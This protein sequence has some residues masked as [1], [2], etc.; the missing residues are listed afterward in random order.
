M[1]RIRT[2]FAVLAMTALMVA[3][4]VAPSVAQTQSG[5]VNV[6]VEIEDNTVIVQVP[7]AVAANVCGIDANVI[8]TQ[9]VGTETVVCTAD[10]D[11]IPTVFLPGGNAGGNGKGKA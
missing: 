8:A 6:A 7:V 1:H 5:L 11:A 2:V 4:A 10:A 3:F 9:F